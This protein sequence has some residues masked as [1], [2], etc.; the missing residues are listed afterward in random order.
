MR[1]APRQAIRHASYLSGGLDI[2]LS[3]KPADG[4]ASHLAELGI[5]KQSV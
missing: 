3:S 4:L 5:H 1:L 2:K